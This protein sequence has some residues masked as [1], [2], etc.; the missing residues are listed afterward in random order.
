MKAGSTRVVSDGGS[1]NGLY[2]TE[3]YGQ[4]W[5]KV[6]LPFTVN[7]YGDLPSNNP[8]N[9]NNY[10]ISTGGGSGF[11]TFD[12]AMA[13][14]PSNPYIIYISGSSSA[15]STNPTLLRVNIQALQGAHSF[16]SHN[17]DNNDGGLLQYNAAG[18][19]TLNNTQFTSQLLQPNTLL[20][21][22][23]NESELN[24]IRDPSNPF[25]VNSTLTTQWVQQFNNTGQGSIIETYLSGDNDVNGVTIQSHETAL[26]FSGGI[27]QLIIYTDPTTGLPRLIFGTDNGIFTGVDDN[28][29]FEGGV[30]T[31]SGGGYTPDNAYLNNPITAASPYPETG[32]IGNRN[33]NLTL[34]QYYYGAIQP[35]TQAAPGDLIY[36]GAHEVGAGIELGD[37]LFQQ[38]RGDR[39]RDNDAVRLRRRRQLR[40]ADR[41]HRARA[42][43]TASFRSAG[44]HQ[45]L[46]GPAQRLGNLH[47]PD[48]R[49]YHRPKRYPMGKRAVERRPDPVRQL[50]R[51]LGQRQPDRHHLE[52]RGDLPH[53]E[54]GRDLVPDRHH[55]GRPICPRRGLRRAPASSGSSTDNNIYA[56]TLGGQIIYTNN[57]GG[58]WTNIS[59][60]LDGSTVQQIVTDPKFGST[61]AYAITL[62]SFST[63]TYKGATNQG[64]SN[65]NLYSNTITVPA[66]GDTLSDLAINLNLAPDERHRQRPEDHA[67]RALQQSGDRPADGVHA[68]RRRRRH[69]DGVHQHDLQRQRD[70]NHQFQRRVGS[71]PRHVQ[72]SRTAW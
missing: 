6:L 37:P 27:H 44:R 67:D 19:V 17:N 45:L 1:M 21:Q 47:Q 56:G 50:R 61:D 68:R 66:N 33:G 72:D 71:V 10:T 26:D 9:A 31:Y 42:P 14:D 55:P 15:D 28:G 12:L 60:G 22:F 8:S 13:V 69:G 46:R 23:T 18:G 32:P 39:H 11:G 53:R 5:T 7:G 36:G 65:T 63:Q 29:T 62:G 54:R 48:V 30:S 16:V 3:D 52:H 40:R 41:P 35:S 70:A 24:L 43:F 20:G 59:A 34:T 25:Q 49:P 64:F 58:T 38:H 57:G 4:N 51:Q 2:V